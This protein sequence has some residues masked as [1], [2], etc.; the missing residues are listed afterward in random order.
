MVMQADNIR[1]TDDRAAFWRLNRSRVGATHVQRQVCT[2][3]M[4][5]S[6]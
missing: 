5:L 1:E 6:R 3:T 2:P 4:D